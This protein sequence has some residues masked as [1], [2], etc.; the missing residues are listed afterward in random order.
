MGRRAVFC[1]IFAGC[2]RL[3]K[4]AR[5]E[6]FAI[7]AVD[8][9]RNS[10]RVECPILTLDLADA[11]A[12]QVLIGMLQGVRPQFIHA[13][14]PCGTGSR[15]RER[16]IPLALRK[17]GAP[18]PRPLRDAQYPLGLPG[19]TA[20]EVAKVRSANLLAAFTIQVFAVSRQWNAIFTIENPKNSWMWSVLE[21]YVKETKCPPTLQAW[22]AMSNISFSNCAHGGDRPKQTTL[23]SSHKFLHTLQAQCPGTHPGTHEHKPYKLRQEGDKWSFDTALESEYPQILC[24]RIVCQ[25]KNFLSP[26]F[27][28]RVRSTPKGAHKQTKKFASLI[29]EYKT[30]V[31]EH[32]SHSLFKQLAPLPTGEQNGSPAPAF[33]IYHDPKEFVNLAT[34]LQHPFD[35]QFAVEDATRTNVFELL[36]E[37]LQRVAKSRLQFARMLAKLSKELASE[38]SRFFASLPNHAQEVLKGKRLVLFKHL[39]KLCEYP[40][41]EAADLMCGLDLTG[42]ASKC[43]IFD[44]KIVPATST[45]EFALLSARWQRKKIEAH[46]IHQDDPK[47][48]QILWEKTLTEVEAGFLQGPFYSV[49]QVQ[50]VLQQKDFVC[51]RRFA[52]MQGGKPRIIDDLKESGVNRTYTAVDKLEL[53]DVDYLAS[54]ASFISTTIHRA[55]TAADHT[56]SVQLRDGRALTGVLH[57][58]FRRDLKWKGKC[59]DLSKAY[60]QVPISEQSRPF[61]VLMV[62]HFETGQPVYFISRSLPFGACSSVFGF[63]RISRALWAIATKFCRTLGGVY[64]DDFPVLEVASACTLCTMSFEGLLKALGWNFTDDPSK[65]KPFEDTFDV[66]GVRLK[67]GQLASGIF[68]LGNKPERLEKIRELLVDLKKGGKVTKR[69]AQVIHGNLNFAMGF[70]MGHTLKIAAR[71]FASLSAGDQNV[72]PKALNNLCDWTLDLLKLLNPR[73]WTA[74][75]T[76]DPV[77]IFTDAAYE[78][79][80]AT[81]GIVFLDAPAGYRTALGGRIPDFLVNVWHE[82]GS[83]QVITLAEAFAALLARYLFRSRIL[84]RRL[85]VFIDN[86]GA[87]HTLIK[88]SSHTLALLQIVQLF[89]S[90]SEYDFALAWIERVPSKSNIADLPSRGD[91]RLA[92]ELIQG[93]P[94]T[95]TVPIVEVAKL[96]VD[97]SSLPT[98]LTH[99]DNSQEISHPSF[100]DFTGD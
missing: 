33:G 54:L 43:T 76:G 8:G 7:L 40:D 50:E 39:L 22:N 32:P 85:L 88:A 100:D 52:I 11:A 4:T 42:V 69:Q 75:M 49:G 77:V 35:A 60:K 96:C 97:F 66:L 98:V 27:D 34:R 1:E 99:T 71:A 5:Q 92:I 18:A 55:R 56:V 38:E 84:K 74:G 62:H 37:G 9:P 89:N 30:V 79:G 82:L 26:T 53:H 91:T 80:V 46:N 65:V 72:S 95:E 23:R 83:E 63:N 16:P 3:S 21:H 58:D 28:F 6:G 25:V 48:S 73:E 31:H 14:L 59:L 57:P 61:A 12:Q 20:F 93:V 47:L 44:T 51:S 94:F 90:C 70:C 67:V 10:H 24:S 87:R 86:E 68:T 78:D 19:L 29:P 36:T 45:P 13:A 64:F 17:R 15:A 81:Y 2:G 41:L